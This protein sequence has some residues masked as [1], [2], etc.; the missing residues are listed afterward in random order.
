[1]D[2]KLFKSILWIISYAVFLV[3]FVLYFGR[4]TQLFSK[5]MGLLAPLFIGFAIA[6]ILYRPCCFFRG[7]LDR[8]LGKTK[9]KNLAQP[10]AVTASYL[11]FLLLILAFF[12]IVLPKLAQSIQLF[13]GSVG[14]YMANFQLWANEILASLNLET[15]DISKFSDLF[16]S[17]VAGLMGALNGVMNTLTTALPQVV[18][19]TGNLIS[20]VVTAFLSVVFSI[21][22]LS[23]K[24]KLLSQCRRVLRAYVPEKPAAWLTDVAHLTAGTFT[25][26][27]SG[28]LVEA[29]IL[30]GLCTVG[31]LFI[32][33]DYAPLIG[34]IVGAS[35]LIPMVGAF[36]GAAVS[37]V[38]LVM[39]SPV[40]TLIFLIFLMVLQQ[41][42]GNIIYPRVVGNNIGLPAIWVLTA[43]TVGGGLLGFV[44]ILLS[45]P[46]AS[47][48]YTLLRRNVHKRL[49]EGTA[50][51]N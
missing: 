27:V 15:L 21:Y 9:A 42:E 48:L 12:S 17:A 6:F 22:M 37:A 32:Q 39:V 35:A 25:A 40:K 49:G 26:F 51:N 29:C 3:L 44:G 36:A 31:M 24:E 10:L 11:V 45:V 38:L 30:G 16:K 19:L 43:V 1:M 33:A 34:M 4:I 23:G 2:K 14:G 5:A 8:A 28:Q 20:I 13:M 50:I 18:T 7:L 47:V 46:V 41:L